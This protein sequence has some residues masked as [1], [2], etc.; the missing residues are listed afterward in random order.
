MGLHTPS[1]FLDLAFIIMFSPG[2]KF[3][4]VTGLR[5]DPGIGPIFFSGLHHELLSRSPQGVVDVGLRIRIIF[6]PTCIM[7]CHS[8]AEC[9]RM[10]T[11]G[12]MYA[13]YMIDVL[14][15]QSAPD[16]FRRS[17]DSSLGMHARDWMNYMY[18]YL[19]KTIP[20]YMCC[21]R[22]RLHHD[23]Q[24]RIIGNN[25]REL[26]ITNNESTH[27]TIRIQSSSEEYDFLL[28][29]TNETILNKK[30]NIIKRIRKK[31]ILYNASVN[32]KFKNIKIN[33][34]HQKDK[35]KSILY[36]PSINPHKQ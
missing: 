33:K 11:F 34:L 17:Q 16:I 22:Q 18:M 2:I 24:Q 6:F 1:A 36:Q 31:S 25:Q 7:G 12:Y 26:I 29:A 13:F 20:P 19:F 3:S 15:T 23:E 9:W 27:L 21:Q 30:K 35:E 5:F 32:L 28:T 14:Y 8:G 4:I 10:I